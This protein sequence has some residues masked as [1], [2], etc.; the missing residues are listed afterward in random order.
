MV[1]SNIY[2][3]ANT[4]WLAN[5]RYGIGFHW[6]A[7]TTPRYGSPLSFKDATE[8]F[9]LDRFIEAVEQSGAYYVIFT[10]THAFQMFPCPHPVVDLILPGRTS[11]RDLLGEIITELHKRNKYFIAYYN[12]SCNNFGEDPE[13]QIAV[14]YHDRCKKK[15]V[16][17]L[18]N[19]VGYIGKKYGKMLDGWWFDSCYALDPRGPSN[20]VTTDM[21]RFFF[22]WEKFTRYAKSG[23]EERL[24]TYNAGVSQRYLYTSHQDYWAGELI[25]LDDR[26]KG[27][28]LPSGLQWQGWLCLDNREWVHKR[29][30][31]D[32]QGP[33][34][35]DEE[36]FDFVSHCVKFNAPVCF[37]VEIFQDGTVSSKAVEQLARLGK[38]LK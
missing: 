5:C 4:D 26:P 20:T 6:T 27:R 24:V 25:N 8:R 16:K 31:T 12:H 15:L 17:N 37:N 33:L 28:Y 23:Y 36:L 10:I 13:W 21:N 19:I 22:P 9:N 29:L 32:A 1:F 30:N 35:T 34:Y 3:R 7:E 11:E 2:K 18:C 38:Y 14:G